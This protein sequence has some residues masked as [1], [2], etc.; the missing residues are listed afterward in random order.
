MGEHGLAGVCTVLYV[1]RGVDQLVALH[2]AWRG[3]ELGLGFELG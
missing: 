2:L 1:E 3:L